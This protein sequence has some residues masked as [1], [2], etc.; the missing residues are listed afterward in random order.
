MIQRQKQL[1]GT[2][3]TLNVVQDSKLSTVAV[4]D[5][6]ESALNK[7]DLVVEKYTRF[8]D[9]SELAELNRNSGKWNDITVEF[10]NLIEKML[11]MASLTDGAFDPTVIDFLELYGYDK[12]YD[13]S[14]L[15]HPLLDNF[16][17]ELAKNRP[18]WEEIELDKSNQRVKLAP[19]QRL[20]LG[21]IG[22]GYAIDLAFDTLV[23]AGVENFLIDAGGDIRVLGRNDDGELWNLGLKH[24]KSNG[25]IQTIGKFSSSDIALACSGSWARKVKNFH[26]IINPTSGKPVE[27]L[28]TVF[29]TAPTATYADAW[30]T[31]LFVGGIKLLEKLPKGMTAMVI[32]KDD[33]AHITEGFLEFIPS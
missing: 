10:T 3:I 9:T 21:G 28:Q 13:F 5:A 17:V 2:T 12:N 30:G 18:T 27:Q 29:V 15:D 22:K 33:K 23:D 32:N 14:K 8:N 25:E 1:M 19:G 20:E 31:A 26:H 7:F 16:V 24:K 4:N 6:L 11:G